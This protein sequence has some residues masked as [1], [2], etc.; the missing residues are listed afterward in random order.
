[1]GKIGF[2]WMKRTLYLLLLMLLTGCA[3]RVLTKDELQAMRPPQPMRL[4]LVLAV[5]ET[6]PDD[7]EYAGPQYPLLLKSLRSSGLFKEVDVEGHT[8]ESPQYIL[9]VLQQPHP[10]TNDVSCGEAMIFPIFTLGIVPFTCK[11]AFVAS[12]RLLDAQG[13]EVAG[14]NAEHPT[15][16]W[17]G[18]ISYPLRLSDAWE[19][20]YDY[21][22]FY[23][24]VA[25]KTYLL[26]AQS[27]KGD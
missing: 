6:A 22:R 10:K 4:S 7:D 2:I 5:R 14:L 11:N 24:M 1:M 25:Y 16:S 26:I 13:I 3:Y 15:R 9:E 18:L 27:G 23:E 19:G 12:Y 21:G 8:Q 17:A 20:K